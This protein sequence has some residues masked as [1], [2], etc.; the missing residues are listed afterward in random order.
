MFKSISPEIVKDIFQFRDA[1]HY[2]LR[3]QK[4]FQIPSIQSVSSDTKSTR[5]LGP[6]IW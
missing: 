3:V 5:F 2:Q 6:K 4:D 1:I